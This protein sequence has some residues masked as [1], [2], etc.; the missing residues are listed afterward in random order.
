MLHSLLIGLP[1]EERGFKSDFVEKD[2]KESSAKCCKSQLIGSLLIHLRS[3]TH[4][5]VNLGAHTAPYATRHQRLIGVLNL[6][7]SL[8]HTHGKAKKRA[9]VSNK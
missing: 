2:E 4:T 7:L 8:S 1:P 3:Q 5:V 9:V 6:L